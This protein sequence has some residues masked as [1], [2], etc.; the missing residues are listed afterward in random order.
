M[1]HSASF[2]RKCGNSGL[3]G[4]ASA[5]LKARSARLQRRIGVLIKACKCYHGAGDGRSGGYSD[6]AEQQRAQQ[7][8][9]VISLYDSGDIR[10]IFLSP[11]AKLLFELCVV[12]D[13]WLKA[14]W[15]L[16]LLR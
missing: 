14:G 11:L 16:C 3:T 8:P 4:F 1:A 7:V 13:T 5:V 10:V 12:G 6:S 9:A 15:V 2:G